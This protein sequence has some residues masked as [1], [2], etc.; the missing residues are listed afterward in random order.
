MKRI[1]FALF[2]L[3]LSLTMA[4]G[5]RLNLLQKDG[6]QLSFGFEEQPS[7]AFEGENLILSTATERLEYPISDLQEFTFTNTPDGIGMLS[8]SDHA[9]HPTLVYKMDGT[10]VMTL[11]AGESQAD[12][13]SLPRGTYIINNGKSTYKITKK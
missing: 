1:L 13:S 5:T 12:T 7:M 6:G 10:L 8:V 4:A 11:P 9:D 2:C 3:S